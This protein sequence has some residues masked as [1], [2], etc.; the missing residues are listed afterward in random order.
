VALANILRGLDRLRQVQSRR[1]AFPSG[2]EWLAVALVLERGERTAE[3][4]VLLEIGKLNAL[5]RY[6]ESLERWSKTI[7]R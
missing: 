3:E 7:A 6:G 4:S 5:G 2:L 1:T